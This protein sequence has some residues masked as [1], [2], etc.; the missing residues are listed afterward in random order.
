MNPTTQ[1]IPGAERQLKNYT[2]LKQTLRN[3]LTMGYRGLLKFR[4]T[5]VQYF[6]VGLQPILFTP[7][8]A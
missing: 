3:S 7:M 6:D 4:R 8:F 5:P 2:G 1:I